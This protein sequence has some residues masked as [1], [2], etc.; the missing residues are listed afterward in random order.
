MTLEEI[1]TKLDTTGYPVSYSSVPLDE[2][3]ARPYICYSETGLRPFSADGIPYY[4]RRVIFVRLYTDIRDEAA[5]AKV[6][7][8][9]AGLYWSKGIEYL[10]DQKIYEIDYEIEV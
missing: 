8:A 7:T 10:E 6:Q 4:T 5:E 9:L 2:A 3:T 1:K